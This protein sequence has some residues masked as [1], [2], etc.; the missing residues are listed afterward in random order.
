MVPQDV[1]DAIP[2]TRDGAGMAPSQAR[3]Y[4]AVVAQ[5]E[6]MKALG[7]V[8]QLATLEK[9]PTLSEAELRQ[10]LGEWLTRE[11]TYLLDDDRTRV[12]KS[13]RAFLVERIAGTPYGR[14]RGREG[15][16]CRRCKDGTPQLAVSANTLMYDLPARKLVE[17]C[18]LDWD[19]RHLFAAL[20]ESSIGDPSKYVYLGCEF[21]PQYKRCVFLSPEFL[22]SAAPPEFLAE[23][24]L[25]PKDVMDGA[26]E[27]S[28][29]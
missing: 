23:S 13:I 19:K 26:K 24:E 22:D 9:D 27:E 7:D 2:H 21:G 15:V 17:G 11:R 16:W 6:L 28:E 4:F 25:P 12:T 14:Y 18:K 8:P 3:R 20:R 10:A 5:G 1:L 29:S